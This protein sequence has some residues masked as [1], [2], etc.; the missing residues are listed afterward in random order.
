MLNAEA[1]K[2]KKL[3][4]AG[5]S[6]LWTFISLGRLCKGA[7]TRGRK[8][9]TL[10]CLPLYFLAYPFKF[11]KVPKVKNFK[12]NFGVCVIIKNEGNYIKEWVD[13]HRLIGVD[14]FYIFDNE[15]TDNT[16]EILK[17]YIDEGIVQYRLIKGKGRQMDAY[18]IT[19]N[20]ERKKCKYIAFI[21]ADE[22][23][24]LDDGIN[25]LDKIDET[26]VKNS[27]CGA[28]ALNW[29]LFGSSNLKEKTNEP[30]IKRFLYHS[31]PD[32]VEN[33]HIKSVVNPR[34]VMD[35]RNPHFPLYKKGYYAYNLNGN[36]VFGPFNEDLADLSV[37][38]NHYFTKS[39]E[40]FMIK[41]NRGFA[42]QPGTRDLEEFNYMNH[43][44]I[45]D[46]S[47]LKY[48]DKL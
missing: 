46:D 1:Y 34:V 31:E 2:D 42:D 5:K 30:V 6:R 47:M 39:E 28:V 41:R 8:I 33:K 27:D 36:K 22:F 12:H 45:F 21:D 14:I 29:L 32:F 15:S 17:P 4:F 44:E 37:R 38:I 35:F 26:F 16:Y 11:W 40:E 25:L 19:I 20:K 13:Y 18:N 7:A 23:I 24:H 43:N 9:A 3:S 10:L 48:V